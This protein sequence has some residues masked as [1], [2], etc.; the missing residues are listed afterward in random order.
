[1]TGSADE[2]ED[3]KLEEGLAKEPLFS[4]HVDLSRRLKEYEQVLDDMPVEVLNEFRYAGRSTLQLVAIL[5]KYT[6][7][8]AL[9]QSPDFK[10][11]SDQYEHA[12]HA[13]RCGYHDLIDGLVYELTKYVDEMSENLS[14]DAIAA[15]GDFRNEVLNDIDACN[16]LIVTSR[17]KLDQ[18]DGFYE[19]LYRD[20][21]PKLLQHKKTLTRSVL[22]KVLEVQQRIEHE[23]D[24]LLQLRIDE[25]RSA[26]RRHNANT[27]LALVGIGVTIVLS[28]VQILLA[29]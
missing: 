9:K 7:M 5:R 6:D 21:F 20:W 15:M 10:T 16:Q 19:E 12:E 28:I 24:A 25:E 14:P 29:L 8:A 23:R 27:R 22:P 17:G 13:F 11:Y 18:R 1:M 26:L 4:L 2:H 3:W